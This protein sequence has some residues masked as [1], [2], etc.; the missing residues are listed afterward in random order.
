MNVQLPTPNTPN[1]V[2]FGLKWFKKYPIIG[3]Y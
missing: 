2:N 3:N 1:D